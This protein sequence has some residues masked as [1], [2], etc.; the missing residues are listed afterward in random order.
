MSVVGDKI[1]V[2][3][4]SSHSYLFGRLSGLPLLDSSARILQSPVVR[5]TLHVYTSDVS[6]LSHSTGRWSFFGFCM[7]GVKIVKY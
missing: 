7:V 1:G 4:E 3:V 6:C 5:L 2:M